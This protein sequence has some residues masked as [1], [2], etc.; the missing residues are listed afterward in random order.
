MIYPNYFGETYDFNIMSEQC[1]FCRL[2]SPD[3]TKTDIIRSFL[4][5]E[6]FSF[7]VSY[8]VMCLNTSSTAACDK[9]NNFQ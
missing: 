7:C 2:K 3:H 5:I 6:I 1:D 9:K 4:S 8:L